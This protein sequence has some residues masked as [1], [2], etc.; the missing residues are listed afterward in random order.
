MITFTTQKEF[1]QYSTYL[2]NNEGSLPMVEIDSLDV[3]KFI[4]I[5]RNKKYVVLNNLIINGYLDLTNFAFSSL[6][7]SRIV[8]NNNARFN[9]S[10]GTDDLWFHLTEFKQDLDIS[11]A[12]LGGLK[13]G[14]TVSGSFMFKNSEAESLSARSDDAKFDGDFITTNSKVVLFLGDAQMKEKFQKGGTTISFPANQS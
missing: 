11:N 1:L 13:L 14:L 12:K 10:I 5:N 6:I 9:N 7:F 3:E 2:D 8:V 4:L